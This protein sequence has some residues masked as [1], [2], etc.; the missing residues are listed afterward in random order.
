MWKEVPDENNGYLQMSPGSGGYGPDFTKLASDYINTNGFKRFW[1]D[2]AK[3]PYLFDGSTFI[4]YDDEES[5]SHKCHYVQREG[6]GGIM[7][8]E[9]KCDETYRLLDAMHQARN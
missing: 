5:I 8:W 3:A 9:Y 7:F 1:D 6:L 2:E 4:S